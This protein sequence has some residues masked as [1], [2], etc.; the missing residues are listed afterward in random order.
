MSQDIQKDLRWELDDKLR[1]LL[2]DNWN[3][4]YDPPGNE[5]LT[6]PALV[7]HKA[8]GDTSFADNIMYKYDRQYELTFIYRD[9]DDETPFNVMSQLEYCRANR[10]FVTNNL[11]HDTMVLYF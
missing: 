2:P 10:H 3:L 7:Y 5:G 1:E 11:H 6:Y 8:S 9:P 4:Y